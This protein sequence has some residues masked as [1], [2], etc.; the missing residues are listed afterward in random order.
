MAGRGLMM[1]QVARH[2]RQRWLVGFSAR[3]VSLPGP[4]SSI[5]VYQAQGYGRQRRDYSFLEDFKR[6]VKGELEKSPELKQSLDELSQKT[7]QATQSVKGV[8]A[9]VSEVSAKAKEAASAVS[10]KVGEATSGVRATVKSSLETTKETLTEAAKTVSQAAQA[11]TGAAPT[12]G[13][14]AG[15]GPEAPSA[16]PGATETASGAAGRAEPK[17]AGEEQAGPQ[18]GEGQGPQAAAG[19]QDAANGKGDKDKAAEKKSLW[20]RLRTQPLSQ[21][22]SDVGS[23]VKDE[24]K[25]VFTPVQPRETRRVRGPAGGGDALVLVKRKESA[26]QRGWGS[27]KEQA[28]ESSFF[29]KLAALGNS[30][31]FE[32]GKDLA[33]D[34]RYRWETSDSRIVHSIQ[35]MQE[36]LFRESDSAAA[37]RAI[38]QVDPEFSLPEFLLHL[39]SDIAPILRAY[40]EGNLEFLKRFCTEE[41]LQRFQGQAEVWKHEGTKVDPS[42]LDVADLELMALKMLGDDPIIVVSFV[43]QQIN[44][45]RDRDGNII[46]GAADDIQSVYYAW[47]MKQYTVAEK[48][49][50]DQGEEVETIHHE[51]RLRDL[52]VRAIHPT[53]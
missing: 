50:T 10:E 45:V 25:L 48:H 15:P 9:Q 40:L 2:V 52:V 1:V 31:V 19:A 23:A 53:I 21:T 16:A 51:W 29:R 4:N 22:L 20:A 44:C 12:T 46:E 37:L 5:A 13:Q 6:R 27:F 30:P 11:A 26:W 18:A 34:L 38:K 41:M 39:R 3:S 7:Q 28:A 42:V 33:E 17:P 35:D 24:L 47:A 14:E 49:L 32:K 43:S 36:R 8:V